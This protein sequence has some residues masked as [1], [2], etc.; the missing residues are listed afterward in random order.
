MSELLQRSLLS[1]WRE[2]TAPGAKYETRRMEAYGRSVIGYV[3]APENLAQ[4]WNDT[5]DLGD[6]DYLVFE[7]ERLTYAEAHDRV[8]AVGAWLARQGVGKGDRVAIAMRNYPEWMLIQWACTVMGAVVVGMNAWWVADEMAYVLNDAAPKVIFCDAERLQRLAECAGLDSSLQVVAVR[9]EPPS[10]AL[11]WDEVIA[12]Q[13]ELPRPRLHPEDDVCIFYT[14]GTTGFP[15]GAQLTH[16]SCVSGLMNQNFSGEV[17]NRAAEIAF[18]AGRSVQ[19]PVIPVA[20]VTTP[21]FHATANNTLAQPAT[22]A[23]GKVVLMRKWDATEAA[24]LIEAERVSHMTGV[25]LIVRE[26]ITSA[27]ATERDLGSL[28]MLGGGGASFPPDLVDKVDAFPGTAFAGTGFGMTEANGS[29]TIISREFFSE[30]PRSCGKVL[31][32]FEIK[33]IDTYADAAGRELG[34][35]CVKGASVIK[36]YLNRPEATAETF[37]DGWLHTGDIGYLD[38]DGYLYVVDRKKDMVL[39]GGENVFCAEVEAA[40]FR[41]PA[42]VEVSVFGVEDE[43]LGEEVAAAVMLRPDQPASAAELRESA[44]RYLAA[45]KVPRWIWLLDEP[46]PR[47]ASGKILRRELR[48]TLR[49]EEAD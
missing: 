15:K 9:A 40:F 42:V 22:M 36:G 32:G 45:Y 23:G 16:L 20:L 43:R 30:R 6:R 21:L 14:S 34:E 4:I 13:G 25:P 27:A 12:E 5:A 1:A 8:R 17:Q 28:F 7:D 49:L 39:R 2:L 35:V 19:P 44:A 33:L 24:R 46:L 41:H 10:G 11:A 38:E 31:P 29:I 26:L 47:N 18:G 3:R 48:T 37:V